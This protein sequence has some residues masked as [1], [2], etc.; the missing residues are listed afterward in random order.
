MTRAPFL[1]TGGGFRIS[2]AGDPDP[3]EIDSTGFSDCVDRDKERA[4]DAR[5]VTCGPGGHRTPVSRLRDPHAGDLAGNVQASRRLP[6]R[7][8]PC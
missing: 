5:S 7:P 3:E 2:P 6:F 4:T 1:R 8:A